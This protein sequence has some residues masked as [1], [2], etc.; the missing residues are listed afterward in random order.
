MV[1]VEKKQ[2]LDAVVNFWKSRIDGL[3]AELGMLQHARTQGR[4]AGDRYAADRLLRE[5]K[6]KS[7]EILDTRQFLRRA[8]RDVGLAVENA[9]DL[10][11]PIPHVHAPSF[12]QGQAAH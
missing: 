2:E 10:R 7:A 4:P 5:I 3:N 8:Q 12:D 6:R 1:P 9:G 11:S